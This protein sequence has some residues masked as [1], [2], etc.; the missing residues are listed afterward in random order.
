MR[1][2]NSSLARSCPVPVMTACTV[3]MPMAHAVP[4]GGPMAAAVP[5]PAAAVAVAVEQQ[6]P[7]T[8]VA[9]APM[10]A[11]VYNPLANAV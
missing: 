2:L 7:P 8:V 6:A 9:S 5:V 1:V 10:P 3:V 11:E 4:I